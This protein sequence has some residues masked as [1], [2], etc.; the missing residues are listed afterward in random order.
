[1]PRILRLLE[2]HG[3]RSTFFVPGLTAD[4]YPRRRRGDRR[5]RPRDRPPQLLAHRAAPAR[6]GRRAARA[7]ARPREPRAD[8]RP[9]PRRL[10]GADVGAERAHPGAAR[11][12]RLPLR[13]EP[14]GRRPAVPA[15]HRQR[16]PRRAPRALDARRLGAVRLRPRAEH[17]G[18][19]REPGEDARPVALGARRPGRRGRAVRPHVPPVPVRPGLPDPG[20]RPA[21]RAR[22]RG[23]AGS[24]SRRSAEIAEHVHNATPP[25]QARPVP[26]VRIDDDVYGG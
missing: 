17:R 24:G 10:P 14:D 9:P 2:R 25:E 5:R 19:H 22:R 15:R 4:R 26:V 21:A 12:V 16:P 20:A 13:L 18:Q 11:R 6:R 3:V 7:R 1:M 23:S 8:P